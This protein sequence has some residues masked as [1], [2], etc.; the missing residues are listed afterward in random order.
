[1]ARRPHNDFDGDGRSDLLWTSDYRQFG[2]WLGHADGSFVPAQASLLAQAP[3]NSFLAAVGDFNGDGRAEV[4]WRSTSGALVDYTGTANGGFSL[5]QSVDL[6]IVGSEWQIVGTGDFNGDGCDDL[7]WRNSSGSVGTWLG[8]ANGGFLIPDGSTLTAAPTDWHVIGNGDF[9]GDGR[10]DIL[11]Q[12]DNGAVGSW[13]S[14]GSGFAYNEA[15]GIRAVS[16]AWQVAGVGDFN[17]DGKDDIL[18]E[19]GNRYLGTWD[20]TTSGGFIVRDTAL[21][22]MVGNSHVANIGDYNGDGRDDIYLSNVTEGTWPML[23][24]AGGGFESHFNP[25]YDVPA[26]WHI[27][28]PYSGAGSWDY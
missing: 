19:T 3:A 9:N 6:P 4:L 12:N 17:G 24:K 16:G 11:W 8:K 5:N 22:E 2:A 13:L 21:T 26:Y 14:T 28:S 18:W 10:T 1:M 20:G 27:A 7:L 25:Y 15:M 23:A